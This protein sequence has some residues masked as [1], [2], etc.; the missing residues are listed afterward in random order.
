MRYSR[1]FFT[2]IELLFV[3]AIISILVAILLP[4]L[5]L[6]REKTRRVSCVANMKQIGLALRS[7]AN[8]W[9]EFFPAGNNASGLKLLLA[10]QHLRSRKVFLCPST[11]TKAGTGAELEDAN[12]DYVYLG[13]FT[14]KDCGY[15]TGI[16]LDRYQTP[17]HV[18]YGNVLFGDGHVLCIKTLH[19]SG[20]PSVMIG[21]STL[22]CAG[23]DA[24]CDQD[25]DP[26]WACMNNCHNTGG[27][28]NDP[29]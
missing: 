17:N 12:L 7:Y 9:E 6:A 26:S 2:L 13:G 29:H 14:T 16:S 27:W 10:G 4:A 15:E 8:E 5:S 22:P 3:I 25:D 23:N 19:G 20:A 28:P 1:S 18:D 21:T 24:E 11:D